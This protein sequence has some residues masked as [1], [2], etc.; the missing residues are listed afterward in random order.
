MVFVRQDAVAQ[1]ESTPNAKS[2]FLHERPSGNKLQVIENEGLMENF[3]N[4]GLKARFSSGFHRRN[5]VPPLWFPLEIHKDPGAFG[6]P[7]NN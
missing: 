7:V 4:H 2:P 3:K 5:A 6:Q 1:G